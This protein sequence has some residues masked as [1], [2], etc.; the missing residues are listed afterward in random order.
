MRPHPFHHHLILQAS[1]PVYRRQGRLSQVA[2]PQPDCLRCPRTR[3]NLKPNHSTNSQHI[4]TQHLPD[5]PQRFSSLSLFFFFSV[6][7]CFQIAL[8]WI[9][10]IQGCHVRPTIAVIMPAHRLTGKLAP[11]RKLIDLNGLW[12]CQTIY[13]T[14]PRTQMQ[15]HELCIYIRFVFAIPRSTPISSQSD[16]ESREKQLPLAV[17]ITHDLFI[18]HPASTYHAPSPKTLSSTSL[19][20]THKLRQSRGF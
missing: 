16:V 18:N 4:R 20:K 1:K 8:L 17:L 5:N 19:V 14:V 7:I 2:R 15:T 13:L 9:H 11:K 3:N 12:T 6:T 10:Q